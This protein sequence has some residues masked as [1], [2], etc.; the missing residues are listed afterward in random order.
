MRA[1][2]HSP[3]RLDVAAFCSEGASLQ[4]AL[5]AGSLPRLAASVLRIGPAT[6]APHGSEVERAD[7]A[8]QWRAR[9]QMRPGQGGE[10][11]FWLNLQADVDVAL[12]C[13]RCLEPLPTRLQ[14]ERSI[15]FVESETQAARLDEESEEDVMA[16]DT[17]LD[18]PELVEDE[19]ILAL[20]LVPRHEH[21]QGAWAGADSPSAP[22]ADDPRPHPFAA[23]AKLRRG[24]G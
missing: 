6:D 22:V 13:Q 18:L 8:A 24:P 7:A 14:V 12:Q 16:L 1:R 20:P 17:R 3:R 11:E 5:P 9:G 2:A 4:G 10:A 15:R 21:C 23:L 19:L